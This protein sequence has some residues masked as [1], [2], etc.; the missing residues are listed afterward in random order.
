MPVVYLLSIGLRL[1]SLPQSPSSDFAPRGH[2]NIRG[3][4]GIVE[5]FRGACGDPRFADLVNRSIAPETNGL[6][7]D[8]S[9]PPIASR[10]SLHILTHFAPSWIKSWLFCS[11]SY[12]CLSVE[13]NNYGELKHT[14][15]LV[16]MRLIGATATPAGVLLS[17]SFTAS[18]TSMAL[19]RILFQRSW[20][21]VSW[22]RDASCICGRIDRRGA[23]QAVCAV[24]RRATAGYR[25]QHGLI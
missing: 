5:T 11:E 2:L 19:E 24:R 17:A 21:W 13:T 4:P 22:S 20:F 15:I 3:S 23:R 10:S 8:E 16:R 18:N 9:S 6:S 7:K 12:V 25:Y 14:R 1:N